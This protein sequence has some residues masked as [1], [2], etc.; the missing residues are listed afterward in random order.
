MAEPIEFLQVEIEKIRPYENNA[1]VHS[2]DQI[3]RIAKSIQEFGFVSP[4]L[5]D[6]ENNL[7]AGHGRLMAAQQIGLLK[8][9]CVF[10]EG[11]TDVQKKAYILADNKLAEFSTWDADLLNQELQDI[12]E[13]N[14]DFAGLELEEMELN[15]EDGYFGDERQRT[16][17]AY[18]LDIAKRMQATDDF[19]Q[20]PVIENDGYTPEKLIGFNYAKT[21]KEKSA[22]IHFFLDD[23]QFERIWN[24]PQKYV[25]ILKEYDCILSPDFSLYIDMPMPMK[26]WNT[27]RSRMIGQ[28][29]QSCGIRVI[30]TI[31]WA[32]KETYKFC[33]LGIPKGSIVA[34]STIGVKDSREALNIWCDGMYAMIKKIRPSKILVYG[35][36]IDFDYGNIEVAYYD[37]DVLQRWKDD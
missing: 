16:N 22:G 20:M 3:D 19:W 25:D 24:D 33:F 13:I 27:Y 12:S 5:I 29:Y 11:L 6:R 21:S 32:E 31:S 34:I 23:Y 26:I 7:I 35:G 10:V 28:Y 1:K 14:L 36:M 9:P 30:P 37:N 17:N 8:V 18:N 15:F 4:C 2:Q